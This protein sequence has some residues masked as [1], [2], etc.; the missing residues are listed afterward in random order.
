MCN[1]SSHHFT[2]R[3]V[4]VSLVP[5]ELLSLAPSLA[6][7]Q[8][9]CPAPSVHNNNTETLHGCVCDDQMRQKTPAAMQTCLCSIWN[10]HLAIIQLHQHHMPLYELEELNA[11]L[12]GSWLDLRFL[13]Y[14]ERLTF[15][16]IVWSKNMFPMALLKRGKQNFFFFGRCIGQVFFSSMKMGYFFPW[17]FS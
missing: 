3:L 11:L 6:P 17:S 14:L 2:R 9:P 16:C 1:L 10:K 13:R 4:Y 7:C 8:N 12:T 5:Q 15:T